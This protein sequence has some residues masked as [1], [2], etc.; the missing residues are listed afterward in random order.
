MSQFLVLLR[1]SRALIWRTITVILPYLPMRFRSQ[2]TKGPNV[3]MRVGI[4]ESMTSLFKTYLLSRK[5]KL[6]KR[7]SEIPKPLRTEIYQTGLYVCISYLSLARGLILCDFDIYAS[8][9]LNY[10]PSRSIS[11]LYEEHFQNG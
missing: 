7:I 6:L 1:F 5:S 8:A 3:C 2:K 11:K 9:R 4:T 10:A